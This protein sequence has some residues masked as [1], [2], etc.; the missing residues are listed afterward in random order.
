MEH[1]KSFIESG[2]SSTVKD[3]VRLAIVKDNTKAYDTNG[4]EFLL[5][6]CALSQ[7]FKSWDNGIVTVNHK[8]KE[9]GKLTDLEY[10]DGFVYA[11]LSGLS[12]DVIELINSPAFR[13]VSQES[14]PLE[15]S[16]NKVTRLKGTGTT[17]VF[18]PES[19]ACSPSMGCGLPIASCDPDFNF[20]LYIDN[21]KSQE[22]TPGGDT[23]TDDNATKFESTISEQKNEIAKLQSTIG[24]LRQELKDKDANLES[25]VQAAV[26]VALESHDRTLKETAEREAVLN[27]LKSCVSDETLAG[28][29]DV[30]IVALKST[31]AAI[32]ET[33]GKHV[34]AN[35]GTGLQSTQKDEKAQYRELGITSIEVE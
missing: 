1:L 2:T 9:Q 5:T 30:P 20:P 15:L 16:G 31:L 26:K 28:F 23:I 27:E 32:K 18:Y 8:Y 3:S 19:A 35:Q 21:Q 34:G 25:T 10:K 11:T 22:S 4:K 14:T 29:K 33:A 24:E 17:L 6:P 7:D 13:G 12:P